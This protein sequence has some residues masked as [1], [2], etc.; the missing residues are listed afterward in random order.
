MM[1]FQIRITQNTF[2]DLPVVLFNERTYGQRRIE[3]IGH[4]KTAIRTWLSSMCTATRSC[5]YEGGSEI[6]Y[7]TSSHRPKLC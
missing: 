2:P 6:T 3:A 5:S 4:K 7:G 1:L